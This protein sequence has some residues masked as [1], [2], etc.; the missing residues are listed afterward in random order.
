MAFAPAPPAEPSRRG[1][2]GIRCEPIA[3]ARIFRALPGEQSS[4]I[5]KSRTSRKEHTEQAFPVS[6]RASASIAGRAAT[7][8]FSGASRCHASL[9]DFHDRTDF[10]ASVPRQKGIIAAYLIAS[11]RLAQSSKLEPAE[12]FLCFSKRPRP[13]FRSCHCGPGPS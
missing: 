3:Q 2:E 4:A 13:L 5:W 9:F 6:A 1:A 8:P 10:H 11:S 7:G 12:L